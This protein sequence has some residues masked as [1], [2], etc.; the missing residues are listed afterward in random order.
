[1]AASLG[2]LETIDW[3]AFYIPLLT[4]PPPTIDSDPLK[5]KKIVVSVGCKTLANTTNDSYKLRDGENYKEDLIHSL[6]LNKMF[7]SLL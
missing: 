7:I 5:K 3:F 1:M 2:P 4:I 6:P